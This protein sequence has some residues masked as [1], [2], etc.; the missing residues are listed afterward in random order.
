MASLSPALASAASGVVITG[1]ASG[2]GARCS[3]AGSRH[4]GRFIGAAG[5]ILDRR[6]AVFLP[7]GFKSREI[8]QSKKT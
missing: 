2:L 4:A 6:P 1:G 8:N 3:L 5:F 7:N